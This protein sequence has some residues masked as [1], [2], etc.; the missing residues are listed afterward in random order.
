[1][2]DDLE[3][4]SRLLLKLCR[5]RARSNRGALP[6]VERG[7]P[8]W[9]AWMRWRRDNGLPYSFSLKQP[10]LTVPFEYPPVDL[11]AAIEDALRACS[12]LKGKEKDDG[13][14]PHGQ[15]YR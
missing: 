6:T 14:G 9:Q 3:L 15:D 11:A 8:E 4:T 7:S 13:R 10:R 1:M 5:L 12:V 2:S